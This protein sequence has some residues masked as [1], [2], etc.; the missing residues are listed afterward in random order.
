M[1]MHFLFPP[2]PI[3][4]IVAMA[5]RRPAYEFQYTGELIFCRELGRM[6]A[7]RRN[8]GPYDREVQIYLNNCAFRWVARDL[9][10]ALQKVRVFVMD[11]PSSRISINLEPRRRIGETWAA[12]PY[13]LVN[14]IAERRAMLEEDDTDEA[15]DTE[16]EDMEL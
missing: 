9:H 14:T 16:D 3:G 13:R 2:T 6:R 8:P 10:I 7:V 11:D 1:V 15:E 12:L 4:Q 5:D